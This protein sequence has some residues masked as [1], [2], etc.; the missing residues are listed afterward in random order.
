[1]SIK[2]FSEGEHPAGFVGFRVA[3]SLGC[4]G[5]TEQ[6]YFSLKEYAFDEAKIKAEEKHKENQLIAQRIKNEDRAYKKRISGPE[7]IASGFRFSYEQRSKHELRFFFQINKGRGKVLRFDFQNEH[8]YFTARDQSLSHYVE[9][10]AYD[11]DEAEML[12]R[13]VPSY[14]FVRAY[15]RAELESARI[16]LTDAQTN[17]NHTR[18]KKNIYQE[19]QVVL[20]A[21][22]EEKLPIYIYHDK[23]VL[24]WRARVEKCYYKEFFYTEWSGIK[25]AFDA[26]LRNFVELKRV[27][28]LLAKSNAVPDINKLHE[29][30]TLYQIKENSFQYQCSVPGMKPKSFR[31]TVKSGE[32]AADKSLHAFRT[33]YHYSYRLLNGFSVEEFDR[34]WQHCRLYIPGAPPLPVDFAID[35]DKLELVKQE[36]KRMIEDKGLQHLFVA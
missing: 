8:D 16:I 15:V 17:E 14:Q 22:S 30:I 12:N 3:S 20:N 32:S 34:R 2:F 18:V 27:E 6:T 9:T 26:A 25:K 28:S 5:L 11:A 36:I 1:M 13:N 31:F 23:A 24:F 7:Y 4:S 10:H 35:E 19:F 29:Y 21:I 33:A